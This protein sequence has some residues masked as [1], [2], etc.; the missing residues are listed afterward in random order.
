MH[1]R[2]L[3]TLAFSVSV[4]LAANISAQE[5]NA[6][7]YDYTQPFAQPFYTTNG[8]E[9]RSASGK[10]GPKYWQNSVD[11]KIDVSLNPDTKEI[12]G[13]EEVTYTNNSPDSMDFV[14]LQLDQNAFKKDS[15]GNA[16][17]P[18]SSSRYGDKGSDFDGGYN[19][20]SVTINGQKVNYTISDT[21]MQIDLPSE[22]KANG[23]VLKFKIDYSFVSPDYGS[24]RMGVL[25]TEYGKIFTVAQW[26]PR[27]AVYDDVL[28][29][30]TLPYLG[31][32]EFYLEYGDIEANIT[33]PSDFYVVASG[34]LLNESKVYSKDQIKAWNQARNSDKTVMIRSAD[35]VKK[36]AGK[37]SSGTKTWSFKITNTRDMAWAASKAF[38]IDA[39]KI[40]LPSGKKSLAVS[41]YPT[42]S[43]GQDAWGRSTEY[44]KGAIEDYSKMWFEYPYPQAI[45]V[46][47]I[48]G[49]MEYPGI[50]FC[51][52]TSKGAS[53]WGVTDHEF[54]H[55]W[56]PM[57]VGSN[58][59]RFGWMDE[60]LN[61]FINDIST[62]HFN[63]GEYYRAQPIQAMAGYLFNKNLE[64]VMTEPD[65]MRERNIGILV[66]Y[67][68][69]SAL[70]VLRE[71]I[72]GKERFDKAFR[73]YTER[74]AYKHPTPDDFFRTI[75]NVAG[76]DLGWFWRGWFINNWQLDQAITNV[77]YV[78]GD[79]KK[80]ALISISNLEQMA[81]PVNLEVKFKDGST[82]EINLPVDIWKRNKDWT[83]QAETNKEI[84]SV[85][86]DPKGN[87][88]DIHPGNNVWSEAASKIDLSEYE[89]VFASQDVPLKMTMKNEKGSLTFQASGQEAYPL[90]YK[91][92]DTFA[93]DM[94]DITITYAKDKKSFV[95]NQGGKDYKFTKE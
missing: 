57:I 74:W 78:D 31:A 30:N 22:L 4:L 68:P 67:K 36:E 79:Y 70:T 41:V 34:E 6:S 69:G 17:I 62:K 7:N 1:F 21:R 86:I 49:G 10:P 24:D 16:T 88:P 53:L 26:F 29:W 83:F 81:M 94:A 95:M 12:V 15:R 64:S 84:S 60:G 75:E 46:A 87:F 8:N 77:S 3:K 50:V 80:G 65:A 48:T 23:G 11:Y 13:S 9:Y 25:D 66:Y 63:N 44:T 14:W 82:Q 59:R 56:F 27:M 92:D 47:G 73:A 2:N 32:G 61:T 28:G 18:L 90:Y 72:L 20:K 76:E 37:K 40:N 93:L 55:T 91:G 89:G 51:R 19:I 54:G 85:T 52:Y 71:H 39:A 38:I 33:V 42:E 58:E 45:N 43:D 35:D 5:A